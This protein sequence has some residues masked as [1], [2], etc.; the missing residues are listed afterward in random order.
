MQSHLFSYLGG[1]DLVETA[2]IYNYAMKSVRISIE[3]NYGNTATLFK[4]LQ[5]EH[6]LRVMKSTR[7][8]ELY[9]VATLF[10]NFY[11]SLYGCQTSN[12]F[13]INLNEDYP[14]FLEKYIKQEYW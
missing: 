9:T 14:N 4:F 7:V 2:K 10:R 12:Y 1:S 6:K 13:D 8:T 3:W 5:Q 11:V